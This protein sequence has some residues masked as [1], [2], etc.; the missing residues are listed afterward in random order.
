M[1]DDKKIKYEAPWLI[2]VANDA[3][4]AV[5]GLSLDEEDTSDEDISQG[6]G[7]DF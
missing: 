5:V 1:E 3:F 2:A 4:K 7:D 6:E